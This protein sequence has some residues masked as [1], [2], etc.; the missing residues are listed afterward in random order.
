MKLKSTLTI[1]LLIFCFFTF[2]QK[3]EKAPLN[4][5]FIKFYSKKLNSRSGYIPAPT[6]YVYSKDV[7]SRIKKT[8]FPTSFNLNTEG[9]VTSVKNQGGTGHCWSFAA[10]G[11]VESRSL[12]LGLGEYDLSEHNLATCNG[13]EWEE[14]GN[15][16]MATA[17][18]SRLSG[19]ILE[20]EDIYNDVEFSC[21]ATDVIPQFYMTE[22]RF[23][24]QDPETIKYYLMN[25]GAIAVSYYSDN[26]LYTNNNTYYYHGS[27]SSNH[28]VLLVGW[29]DTK[30]TTGGTGAWIIKNSWGPYWG[31]NGFFYMSYND[32]HAIE[33]PTIYPI[34]KEINNIDTLLMIDELG[35]ISSYGY[36]DQEDY[37]LIKY[38]VSEQYNFNQIG[39]YIGASNSLIDIEIFQ[40]KTNDILTDTI[41][42]LYNVYADYPGY[43]TFDIPFSA[44]GDFYIKI[45]YN[46]PGNNYPIPVELK[47]SDYA[48][49]QI[50]SNICWISNKGDAWQQI[51]TGT[52]AEVDLCIRAY[53]SKTG[54]Q[55][56]F[57]A[58]KSILCYDSDVTFTNTSSGT[59]S[60]Y[61][62]DFGKDATPATANTE[63]PHTVSY[64][65]QGFKTIKLVIE[66]ATGNK[67]S[68]INY[69][70]IEVKEEINVQIL[71]EDTIFIKENEEIELLANGADS[72]IWT[73]QSIVTGSSTNSKV[74][75]ST[76]ADT[77]LYVTGTMG[78][79]VSKDSTMLKITYSPDN[80]DVCDATVLPL[81]VTNGPFTN[82]NATVQDNEPYPDTTSC[83]EPLQWCNESGLQNSIWFK[84]TAG[85][86]PITILTD[87]EWDN[88]IALYDAASCDDIISG[89][90]SK[91]E[92]IAA[93]DDATD[94]DFKANILNPLTLTEGK[95]YWLQMDGS[96]GGKVGSCTIFVKEQWPT[97]ISSIDNSKI[98][99]YPNP[100]NGD[101]KIDLSSIQ[102]IDNNTRIDVVSTTG[103]I[104]Y[105][106]K[107]NFNQLEYDLSINRKGMF[108]LRVT[109]TN[110]KYSLPIILK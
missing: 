75:V 6:T 100:S 61:T 34:R 30:T 54:I 85:K 18:Y 37:A 104:I 31:D 65:S 74:Q 98:K 89:D 2:A 10:T 97:G 36:R 43:H 52:S 35:Q 41:A 8:D 60:K 79:C 99:V 29:D 84:F 28:G 103:S 4:K 69:N 32:S 22:S 14:G 59:I 58:D 106:F 50:E 21:S 94:T 64:S 109:T 62:W 48:E 80:D 3:A 42:K 107:A 26:S 72:Y 70:Y 56:S 66:D 12:I 90:E 91:Y 92:L 40:T 45:K 93:N 71:A 67:D 44:N 96:G 13:F 83:T 27:E 16:N 49:P 86:Y 57:T 39:T 81:S 95:T 73:P 82:A 19:P 17:Y 55:S 110:N 25:Y 38:N 47:S 105:S 7:D 102:N 87:G 53:G 20:S 101:F 23:L 78:S 76:A 1:I 15:Q 88:Q 24:P 63:G 46:T 5:E 77:Y 68:F 11:A 9:Y 108:I 33:N 51:G